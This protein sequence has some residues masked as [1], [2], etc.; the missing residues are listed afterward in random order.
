MSPDLS[1]LE[2]D[3]RQLRPAALEAS[4]L[5]R[6]AACG[7]NS[8]AELP[9]AELPPAELP[10][11][12]QRCEHQLRRHRAAPLPPAL[13]A[14]LAALNPDLAGATT[15]DIV[16]FPV[17]QAT[18]HRHHRAWW[19]AAAVVA[20]S[21]ALAALLVPARHDSRVLAAT[22]PQARAAAAP[23]VTP[24]AGQL[25]P[26]SFNRGLSEARDEGVIWQSHDQ[27]HRVLKVVYMDR[28]TLKNPAGQT[29]QVDQPRVEYILV[30]AK[31]D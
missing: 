29:Y 31:T 1:S 9:T 6:L 14:S 10:A 12:L 5:A 30:P 20:L 23:R 24:P 18:A 17:P 11:E 3:L 27:P 7:D 25:T 13:L 8:R 19:S 22:V 16:R 15:P 4:L 28:V 21:G 26:A 2:S